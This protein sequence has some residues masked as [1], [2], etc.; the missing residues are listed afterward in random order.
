MT[1]PWAYRR[2][3]AGVQGGRAMARAG[4]EKGGD[5]PALFSSAYFV[6]V[7]WCRY[8]NQLGIGSALKAALIFAVSFAIKAV[9][10]S[11][12][13]CGAFVA[14]VLGRTEGGHQKPF[15]ISGLRHAN[16]LLFG[17]ANP[18]ALTL[19][20]WW[21]K[22]LCTMCA[23]DVHR[24]YDFFVEVGFKDFEESATIGPRPT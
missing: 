4:N 20:G 23:Q 8:S 17:W 24:A 21:R 11:V 3:I 22:R 9:I 10:V 1:P 5:H 16:S 13:Y 19:S 15:G 12:P 14:A 18:P 7:V 6:P 2:D